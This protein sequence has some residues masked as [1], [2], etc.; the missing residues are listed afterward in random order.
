V[1]RFYHIKPES[2]SS[3]TRHPAPGTWHLASGTWHLAS[4]T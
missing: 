3:G 4:G 2:D 1:L